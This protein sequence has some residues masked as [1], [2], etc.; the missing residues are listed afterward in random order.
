MNITKKWNEIFKSQ[1][2]ADELNKVLDNLNTL[3]EQKQCYL[4]SD[5]QIFTFAKFSFH[6]I[7]VVILGMDP[8]PNHGDAHGLSFSS[9]NPRC[10]Y[11]L[12]KIFN[13][14][15]K[16]GLIQNKPKNNDLSFWAA[17]GILL[18]NT[19]LTVLP[20]KPGSHIKLWSK[21]SD[22]LLTKLSEE[23][24][25]DTIWCFW[26]DDAQKKIP[27]I[28]ETKHTILKWCHPAAPKSPNFSDCD[29]FLKISE[30]FPEII[31]D[32]NKT[33][34]HF[35]TD[36]SARGNQFKNCRAS[37]GVVCT[38]GLLKNKSWCGEL[39]SEIIDF[40]NE[41]VEARPTNIRAEC[42]AICYALKIALTLP[43]KVKI[44]SDSKF[45]IED[46]YKMYIPDWVSKGVKFTDKKNSD[47][48]TKFWELSQ[49]AKNVEFIF[50]NAWHDRAE[51][52]EPNDLYIW[53]GNRDAE[54]CAESVIFQ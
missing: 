53:G 40:K 32:E 8:Y 24:P 44:F 29:H 46:M 36:C 26:G 39:K 45:W 33:E 54:K 52:T 27:L 6:Q 50:V 16:N 11:S 4:P 42:E 3:K 1:E 12:N 19:A 47:L 22:L 41:K 35:F 15:Q 38:K 13:V 20:N 17:Q 9:L 25:K 21:F 23:L 34:T 10:P 2:I 30:R 5:D 49:K 31:W 14:L 18:L 51:P 43:C 7:K 37:W 48:V 28:D